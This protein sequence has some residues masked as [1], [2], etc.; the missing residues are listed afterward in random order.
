MSFKV[1]FCDP[2]NS[3]IIEMGIIDRE[4]VLNLFEKIPWLDI[5]QKMKAV[6]EKDIFYS[7]SFEILNMNSNVGITVSIIDVDEWYIFFKR[8]K[9]VRKL[10]GLLNKKDNY[11]TEVY[12]QS[13]L[14]VRLALKAF[15]EGDL[16]YLEKNI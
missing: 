12:N 14:D 2:L 4:N 5:L 3:D 7:P 11:M 10:L 16:N 1:S 15:L 9:L 13:I 8:P 6:D